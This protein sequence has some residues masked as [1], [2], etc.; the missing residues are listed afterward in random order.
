MLLDGGGTLRLQL[1]QQVTVFE[2]IAARKLLLPALN[3]AFGRCP[4]FEPP[5]F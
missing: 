1:G 2:Q 5:R 3:L 4:L